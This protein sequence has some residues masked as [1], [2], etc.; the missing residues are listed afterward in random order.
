[1]PDP[2]SSREPA[3]ALKFL[4]GNHVAAAAAQREAAALGRRSDYTR[5]L[6]RETGLKRPPGTA[7]EQSSAAQTRGRFA[8]LCGVV[9]LAAGCGGAEGGFRERAQAICAEY[10]ERIGEI[11]RP[12]DLQE[13][14]GT[15][16]EVADL[17]EEQIAEL[18]ELD[19]PGGLAGDFE[20]WLRLNEEA[21]ENAREIGAAAADDDQE[22]INE[23]AGAAER[24]ELDADRLARDL[25]LSACMIE[26]D[27]PAE[28]SDEGPVVTVGTDDGR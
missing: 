27:A 2:N 23:L 24:N 28:P 5:P 22:R 18:R 16:S 13:L 20:E 1:L 25:E 12:A 10:D 9:V 3:P 15:S 14:A 19:P 8:A 4:H 21:V 7:R 6:G 17:L 26:T 11:A